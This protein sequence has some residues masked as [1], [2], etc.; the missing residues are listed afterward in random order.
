MIKF[1]RNA[2]FVWQQGFSLQWDFHMRLQF[3][4]SGSES[5]PL[6]ESLLFLGSPPSLPS[7]AASCSVSSLNLHGDKQVSKPFIFTKYFLWFTKVVTLLSKSSVTQSL[8]IVLWMT[9]RHPPSTKGLRCQATMGPDLSW[10]SRPLHL[11]YSHL[12]NSRLKVCPLFLLHFLIDYLANFKL[13]K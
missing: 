11:T 1:Q 8:S 6:L 2:T 7:A 13:V 3:L 12:P 5:S 4:S 10:W 9:T